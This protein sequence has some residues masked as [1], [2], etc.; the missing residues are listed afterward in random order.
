[1]KTEFSKNSHR[2]EKLQINHSVQNLKKKNIDIKPR[3]K[4]LKKIPIL[5]KNCTLFEALKNFGSYIGL[6]KF[7]VL[8]SLQFLGTLGLNK[9]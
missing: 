5:S 7:E 8:I 9:N 2:V 4:N 6:V 3:V 1:M